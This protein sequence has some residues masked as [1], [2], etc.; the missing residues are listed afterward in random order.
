LHAQTKWFGIKLCHDST[1]EVSA[2]IIKWPTLSITNG[3]FYMF[4][5]VKS[6]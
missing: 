1:L 3:L 4:L 5:S 6:N 2:S